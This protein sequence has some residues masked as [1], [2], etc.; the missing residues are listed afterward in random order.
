MKSLLLQKV[1]AS[2]LHFLGSIL[3]LTVLL[4]IIFS[5]WYPEPFREISGL[6]KILIILITVDLI[7]GPVLTFIFYQKNKPQLKF[8]LTVIII[9]QLS[10]LFYGIYTLYL[11]HPAFIAFSVDRFVL[12]PAK[13]VNSKEAKYEEIKISKLWRPKLVYAKLPEDISKRNQLLFSVVFHK[14]PDLELRPE[15]Y[16][17]IE[18][19]LGDMLERAWDPAKIFDNDTKQEKLR[20]FLKKQQGKTQD[21]AFFPLVGKEKDIVV[22]I[23]RDNGEIIGSIDIYPW[24]VR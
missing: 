22:A 1:K 10:A 15:Y 6:K 16:E 20:A 13:S 2:S 8:D 9:V 17:P 18:Q 5:V 23:R 21:F 7:L 14:K 4:L 19:H 3:V 11:G 12:V 24:G